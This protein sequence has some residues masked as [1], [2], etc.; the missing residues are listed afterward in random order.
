MDPRGST[1]CEFVR[2]CVRVV[3]SDVWRNCKT[4]GSRRPDRCVARSDVRRNYA[5]WQLRW[6]GVLKLN[7]PEPCKWRPELCSRGSKFAFACHGGIAR[8]RACVVRTEVRVIACFSSATF[9]LFLG[10]REF[11]RSLLRL[12]NPSQKV[13]GWL[14]CCAVRYDS[15]QRCAGICPAGLFLS[16]PVSSLRL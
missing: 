16:V 6:R 9:R 8:Q 11:R 14:L 1:V 4:A 13:F 10:S 3:R 12:H 5:G 15:I 7:Q 2:Q